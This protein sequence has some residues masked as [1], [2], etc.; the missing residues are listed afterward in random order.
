MICTAR[1]RLAVKS[2]GSVQARHRLLRGQA[3]GRKVGD[4]VQVLA[5]EQMAGLVHGAEHPAQV[6]EA[7]I[8]DVFVE[9]VEPGAM[10]SRI[11]SKHGTSM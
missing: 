4:D 5:T 7:E 8:I 11:Q 10:C 3:Q 1:S 6:I 2:S 9:Q